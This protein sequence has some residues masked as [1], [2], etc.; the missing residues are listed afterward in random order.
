MEKVCIIIR[1]YDRVE[2]LKNCISIIRDTWKLNDYYVVVVANGGAQ[3]FNID[4][5]S[6]KGIDRLVDLENNAGH[7][8]GNAQLLQEGLAYLPKNCN[9]TIILEADTWI[10]GDELVERYINRL[11]AEQAVWASAQ[12]YS[13]L[14]SLATD[15]AIIDTGFLRS[16]PQVFEYTG[17]PECHAANYIINKGLKFIY[18]SENMPVHLPSYIKHYPFTTG[19]RFNVFPQGKMV[20][21]HIELL[22]GGMEKKK[23]LF[24]T[25]AGT[26]YFEGDELKPD[27][28]LKIKILLAIKLSYMFPIKGWVQK[29]KQLEIELV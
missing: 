20:T 12:W 24:N 4:T 15:F 3:G 7:L 8:K 16:N 9:Y 21:H 28:I 10:Y 6:Q 1:V 5:E 26:G 17:F 14:Y 22:S 23:L 29:D 2:D 13:H 18:I 11:K 27:K 25:L 19:I